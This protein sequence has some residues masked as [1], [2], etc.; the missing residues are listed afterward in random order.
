MNEHCS[1]KKI[2]SY[3]Y[4]LRVEEKLCLLIGEHLGTFTQGFSCNTLR[5]MRV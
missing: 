2:K 4:F 5:S 3:V 1:L